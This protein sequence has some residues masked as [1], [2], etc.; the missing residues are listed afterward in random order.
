MPSPVGGT[1]LALTQAPIQLPDGSWGS[2]VGVGTQ[3][4]TPGLERAQL[5]SP[6][7]RTLH[8]GQTFQ[9]R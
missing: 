5:H 8:G 2:A 3:A 1:W 7:A 9:A 4:V 6:Q